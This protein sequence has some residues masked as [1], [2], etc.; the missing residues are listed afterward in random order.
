METAKQLQWKRKDASQLDNMNFPYLPISAGQLNRVDVIYKSPTYIGKTGFSGV[1]RQTLLPPYLKI[2]P[3]MT[4][5]VKG[6]SDAKTY[7]TKLPKVVEVDKTLLKRYAKFCG[8]DKHSK[9]LLDNR[10]YNLASS[11]VRAGEA[12]RASSDDQR[13]RLLGESD[14][15]CSSTSTITS[16]NTAMGLDSMADRSQP[17]SRSVTFTSDAT[18]Y[19]GSGSTSLG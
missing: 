4:A 14:A 12:S 7:I 10:F 13:K 16:V 3:E 18:S 17:L 8:V 5:F 2:R 15:A 1:G 9:P 6:C 11:L 19:S